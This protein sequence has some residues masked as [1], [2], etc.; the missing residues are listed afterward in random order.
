M[1][2]QKSPFSQGKLVRVVK[3]SV[4][5]VAVDIRKNSSTYGSWHSV[6]LSEKNKKMLWIP[7][8]FAH[9]FLVLENNTIFNYKCTNYYNRDSESGIRWNDHS[10]KID[11]QLE[12][13][14]TEVNIPIVNERDSN[15]PLFN[16]NVYL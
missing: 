12:N 9:G 3:G 16:N 1:H 15:F 2:F 11:W 4:L 13:L 8:G 6:F 10:L 14:E 5:D 7:E